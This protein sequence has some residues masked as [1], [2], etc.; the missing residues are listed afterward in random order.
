MFKKVM[1]F[2]FIV[3]GLTCIENLKGNPTGLDG[4]REISFNAWWAEQ[5]F[6]D[7]LD[8]KSEICPEF[9]QLVQKWQLDIGFPFSFTYGGQ[10]SS[11]FLNTWDRR[12]KD[13]IIDKTRRRR[14]LVLTDPQTGLEVRA[15]CLI[16]TDTPGIDWTL[17]FT[18]TGTK[19]TPIIT[20]VKALDVVV[21][22]DSTSNSQAV[23]HRSN[24][25]NNR[26]D[27]WMEFEQEIKRGERID[28]APKEGWPSLGA[29]PF[30]NLEWGGGGVI[31]AIGWTCQWAASIEY[32]KESRL[33]LRAGMEHMHLK[34]HPGETIRSPRILQLYWFGDHKFRPY[35]L[36]RQTMLKHIMPRINGE[37]VFPPIA[38]TTS[39][40]R[41]LNMT[42]E[43]IQLD[44][45]EAM[46]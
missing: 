34:L 14:T 40:I 37:L 22:P 30:F 12:I 24:G 11:S 44:Y 20:Q 36:F 16:Y 41:E 21:M 5:A 27:D 33:A 43:A 8:N 4:D 25:S 7:N 10:H 3:I 26:S 13:E 31:T 17:H 28:F 15:V 32:S 23:L 39:A 45:L 42:T 46:K 2:I 1:L 19:D 38:H 6:S 9:D 18:N 35:N 29:N